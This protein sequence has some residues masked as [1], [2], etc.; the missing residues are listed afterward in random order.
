M[1]RLAALASFPNGGVGDI[2]SY[3]DGI[4]YTTYDYSYSRKELYRVSGISE[5]PSLIASF[6]GSAPVIEGI[7]TYGKDIYISFYD[8]SGYGNVSGKLY[9]SDG[10]PN[11]LALIGEYDHDGYPLYLQNF[12]DNIVFSNYD[13]SGNVMQIDTGDASVK[14]IFQGTG[15]D[16]GSAGNKLYWAYRGSLYSYSADSSVVKTVADRSG[17]YVSRYSNDLLAASRK[18]YFFPR[19]TSNA[20]WESSGN[21]SPQYLW[22]S[23]G[24]DSGTF[25]VRAIE[26]T[27]SNYSENSAAL[28]DSLIFS[29]SDGL[30]G[31]ELW[32][33]DGTPEGTRLIKDINPGDG[34]S[35]IDEMV[36]GDNYVYFQAQNGGSDNG[37]DIWRT[38]GTESGT[39]K[40]FDRPEY[41]TSIYPTSVATHGDSLI[42]AG[43]V[44]DKATGQIETEIWISDGS[45]A[46]TK[47][48]IDIGKQSYGSQPL[49]LHV[50]NNTLYFT[51]VDG[52]IPNGGRQ[53]FRYQ[54]GGD[55]NNSDSSQDSGTI[56]KEDVA[57][58]DI[59]SLAID[60]SSA[61]RGSS[62]KADNVRGTDGSEI[63]GFG[64]G[65]D[66]LIGGGSA[67]IFLV[68]QSDTFGK[69]GAD[70][71]LDF[72]STEG[73]RILI[74]AN[75]LKGLGS[76][77]EFATATDKKSLKR[78]S[79]S[80]A[81]I[82]YYSAKGELYFN[83][84]G[85]ARN[86]GKGGLFAVLEGSPS[87]LAN[88]IGVF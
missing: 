70:K 4:L 79:S 46:G 31:D 76:S 8:N 11:N 40:I 50:N 34:G 64:K 44:Q 52:S 12:G 75:A 7:A 24:S 82:I 37:F 74:S 65:N 88:D 30:S 26:P 54:L 59:S 32:V 48:L 63:L 25:M 72:N 55:I 73:D 2:F 16:L 77:P 6:A 33:S 58:V 18:Y 62:K 81:E 14:P 78:L 57:K 5:S 60:L 23:D 87:L 84:N 29:A 27:P 61:L 19:S 85:E 13:A 3:G 1:A 68:D 71:I 17:G 28:G 41:W 43:D 21:I 53:L 45:T 36:A 35:R 42:F 22:R 38:D 83:Q 86:Y 9:K 80:T 66:V 20:E 10:T 15:Q 51:A 56:S 69:K 39:I 49:N 67:D 47:K